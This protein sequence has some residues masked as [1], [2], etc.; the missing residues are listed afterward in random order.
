V[1]SHE[2]LSNE[3]HDATNH[4]VKIDIATPCDD[5][6]DESIEQGSSGKGMQVVVVDHYDDYVK[7]K[8]ENEKLEK[9]LERKSMENTIVIETIDEDNVKALEIEK[10]REENKQL[11][12]ENEHLS[13]GLHKFTKGYIFKVSYS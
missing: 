5:L 8:N 3:P 6:I 13:T 4:V 12:K 10:L 1:L 9:D 7:L 2:L 11:K